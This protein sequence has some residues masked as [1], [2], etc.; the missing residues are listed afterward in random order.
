MVEGEVFGVEAKSNGDDVAVDDDDRIAWLYKM[1]IL[2]V[3]NKA[4]L[5]VYHHRHI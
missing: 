2:Y 4:Y 5:Y 1:K 3:Y